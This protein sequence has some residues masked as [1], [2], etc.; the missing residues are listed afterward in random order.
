MR[1]S[2]VIMLL[3]VVTPL[4]SYAHD[5]YTGLHSPQGHSVL[6]MSFRA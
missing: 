1:L 5:W 3:V 6:V 2:I 4:P